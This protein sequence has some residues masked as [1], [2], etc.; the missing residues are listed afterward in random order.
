M[1]DG[2]ATP[3][4]AQRGLLRGSVERRGLDAET[5]PSRSDSLSVRATVV[6]GMT[7]AF[8]VPRGS[9]WMVIGASLVVFSV[10]YAMLMTGESLADRL[11]ISPTVGM[12]GANGLILSMALLA[13]WWRQGSVASAG[14]AAGVL[15]G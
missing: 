6:S 1:L 2:V 3:P 5:S 14:P 9:T 15:R 12:W 11:V 13:A 7:I 4:C 8:P 10:Y